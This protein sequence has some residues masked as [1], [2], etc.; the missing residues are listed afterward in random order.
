MQR[1]IKFRGKDAKSNKWI[2]GVYY[3]HEKVTLCPIGL[4]E[5]D[6]KENE[7][8][9]IIN[10][11]FSDWNLPAKLNCYEV[12]SETVGQCTGLKDKKGKAIYEGDII[13]YHFNHKI[14]GIVKFGEY[15]NSFDGDNHGGHVGFHLEWNE[16]NSILRVDLG[17][18]IKVSE[19]IGNIY[20]NP[21]LLS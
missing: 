20:D 8:H 7:L 1:E 9:L 5:K 21:E 17:Y 14:I 16:E 4:S 13:P 3:Q 18:W 15:H 2:Y 6:I 12:I 19:I 10:G 11:G